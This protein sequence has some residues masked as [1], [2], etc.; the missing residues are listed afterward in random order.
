MID[1]AAESVT[2]MAGVMLKGKLPGRNG[3]VVK[4]PGIIYADNLRSDYSPFLCP[5]TIRLSRNGTN[6]KIKTENQK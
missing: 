6:M 3:S 5:A 2:R 4:V 1:E